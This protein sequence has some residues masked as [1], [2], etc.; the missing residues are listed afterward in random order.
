MTMPTYPFE[1]CCPH[2]PNAHNRLRCL[3]CECEKPAV[4]V[5][6]GVQAGTLA[7]PPEEATDLQVCGTCRALLLP[8]DREA[9][10]DWHDR[11][12]TRTENILTAI[13]GLRHRQ[14][15][16]ETQ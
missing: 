12:N 1:G 2:G 5:Q 9:H 16:K 8:T 4:Q 10:L 14:T 6:A 13:A 7:P 15:P 11:L 3:A